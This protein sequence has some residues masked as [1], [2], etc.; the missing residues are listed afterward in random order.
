[1]PIGLPAE[2]LRRRP[3]IR[4][5]ERDLAAATARIGVATA[6]LYPQFSLTGAF[7]MQA[8]DSHD[9][10]EWR[11][12]S[13][14]YGPS[15]RWL[16]FDAGRVRAAIKART[17]QQEQALIMYEQTVL[18]AME[19]VQDAIVAFNTELERR[20]SLRDAVASSQ[21]SV[22]LAG[23]LYRQGLA[24]FLS[25]LDAQRQLFQSQE[26]LV[27]SDRMLTT[28]LISLYKALGG[29]WEPPPATQPAAAK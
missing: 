26:A 10:L 29:G 18:R 13:W 11:S 6:D 19:E 8:S 2:L 28:S 5:A 23:E 15:F 17:A 4:R 24:D 3:D 7:N 14:S 16:I 27:L 22:E 21:E 9:L 20:K 1:V 25:V 12:R